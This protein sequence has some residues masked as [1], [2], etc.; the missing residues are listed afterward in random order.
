MFV[1]NAIGNGKRKMICDDHGKEVVGFW[2]P[3]PKFNPYWSY[4]LDGTM[5]RLIPIEEEEILEPTAINVK[6]V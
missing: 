6:E 5:C 2:L 4:H 3:D 1:G